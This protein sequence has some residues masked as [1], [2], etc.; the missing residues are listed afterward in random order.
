M[1]NDFV[2]FRSQGGNM[3]IEK[4][5]CKLVKK[6]ILTTKVLAPSCGHLDLSI[7]N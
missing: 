7:K 4:G 1:L 3:S 5:I 6:A 2:Y